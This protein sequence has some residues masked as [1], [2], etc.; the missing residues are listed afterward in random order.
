M[1]NPK[2]N[3]IQ[4]HNN[5]LH[6][7]AA[8]R[9]IDNRHIY[10]YYFTCMYMIKYALSKAINDKDKITILIYKYDLKNIKNQL[11]HLSKRIK[12]DKLAIKKFNRV[13]NKKFNNQ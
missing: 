10:K 2:F 12:S 9:I 7:E 4:W 6:S 1:S 11:N 5:M 8:K 3:R 13:Y